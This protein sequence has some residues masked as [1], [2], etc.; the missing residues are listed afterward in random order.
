[1][2]DMDWEGSGLDGLE[3]E[4]MLA[5]NEG[6]EEVPHEFSR[7]CNND[8]KLIPSTVQSKTWVKVWRG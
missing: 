5:S 6:S 4:E 1:M 3:E 8:P 7:C 2:G